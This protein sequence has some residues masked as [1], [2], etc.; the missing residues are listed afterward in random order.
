[1]GAVLIIITQHNANMFAVDDNRD[2][3]FD[4]AMDYRRLKPL[5]TISLN[6][7]ATN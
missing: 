5:L 3:L 2:S 4:S 6:V 1:M 7:M